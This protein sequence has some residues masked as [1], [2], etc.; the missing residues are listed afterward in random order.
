MTPTHHSLPSARTHTNNNR[1]WQDKKGE[2]TMR[3]ESGDETKMSDCF[4]S[5]CFAFWG[6]RKAG[7]LAL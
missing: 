4:E 1:S 7:T 2:L 5:E 6:E 3:I